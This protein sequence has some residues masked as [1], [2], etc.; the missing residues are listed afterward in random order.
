MTE[1]SR[2]ALLRELER[3]TA[4]FGSLLRQADLSA[5]IAAC[6]DFDL[7]GLA[8]HLGGIHVWATRALASSDPPPR[9]PAG[10]VERSALVDWYAGAARALLDALRTTDPAAPC[11]T[12][13]PPRTTA[14]WLRRQVHETTVHLWDAQS[15]LGDP[16]PL[17]P[18]LS[19]DGVDE[20]LSVF[21]P[22][23]VDLGRT[24]PVARSV[25]LEATDTGGRWLVGDGDGGDP[26][27][28]VR[29]P[30]ASLL[31]LLWKRTAVADPALTVDGD[32][33]PTLSLALTP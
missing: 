28:T 31:L 10:P 25:G 19:A 32:P 11:F 4:G 9:P 13:G 33:T 26:V 18:K 29:G 5:R 22:R 7:T 17:D 6:P 14:F 24:P 23:Q 15:A 21:L 16:E 12:F 8:H 2:D 1:M 3:R 27:A 20:V 30:A